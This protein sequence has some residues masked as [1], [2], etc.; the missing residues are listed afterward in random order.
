M[1]IY[2]FYYC[3]NIL[4]ETWVYIYS[5]VCIKLFLHNVFLEC[6]VLI[7]VTMMAEIVS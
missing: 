3:A 1:V 7:K 4:M 2:N 5:Y 6:A